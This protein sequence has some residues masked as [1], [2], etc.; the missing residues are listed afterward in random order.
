MI[1]SGTSP[2]SSFLIFQLDVPNDTTDEHT[3]APSPL[4]LIVL[5]LILMRIPLPLLR[6]IYICT[7]APTSCIEAENGA[8]HTLGKAGRE[9]TLQERGTLMLDLH[10]LL[11][12]QGQERGGTTTPAARLLLNTNHIQ[13]HPEAQR[14]PH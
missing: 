6:L 2:S 14:H 5:V 12:E 3:I 13:L 10:T 1:D 9:D 8:R 11:R 4:T 7:R